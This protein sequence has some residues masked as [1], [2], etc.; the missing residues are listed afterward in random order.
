MEVIINVRNLELTER[1]KEYVEKRV[2]RLDRYLDVLDEAIV[3]LRV[4]ETARSAADRQI[5]QLTVRGKSVV[6]RAED[7]AD[8]IYPAVD[9]VLEKVE[10]QIERYKGRRW[11][12]RGDGRSMGEL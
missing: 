6:L 3:D 2:S 10:R 1:L 4:V 9:S 5:A 11:K 12:S 8:D 7:R